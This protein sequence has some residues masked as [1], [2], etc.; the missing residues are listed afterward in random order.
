V[1]L[2]SQRIHRDL[3]AASVT[4][5]A[6]WSRHQ[7]LESELSK[8][9][10]IA[11]HHEIISWHLAAGHYKLALTVSTPQP[12]RLKLAI[13]GA[14]DLPVLDEMLLALRSGVSQQTVFFTLALP[15]RGVRLLAAAEGGPL[16]VQQIS[17]CRT[18][19]INVPRTLNQ[20]LRP[21]LHERFHQ[22]E[23]NTQP[24]TWLYLRD[25][26]TYP[27]EGAGFWTQGRTKTRIWLRSQLRLNWL[28]L[29]F[30]SPTHNEC[31]VNV[32][33]VS[34]KFAL[35]P[36]A[37]EEWLLSPDPM[38][39]LED[40]SAIYDIAITSSA[41]FVPAEHASYSA[42]DRRRLGIFV[43]VE[44]NPSPLFRACRAGQQFEWRESLSAWDSA[45][46]SSADLMVAGIAQLFLGN[47]TEANRLFEL[48]AD[49]QDSLPVLDRLIAISREQSL[50]S[51]RR[52]G[53]V[54]DFPEKADGR[55]CAEFA[56]Q[57][58]RI[59]DVRSGALVTPPS[60]GAPLF[61]ADSSISL[62]AL[63]LQPGSSLGIPSLE[64]TYQWRCE[65]ACSRDLTCFVHIVK[66]GWAAARGGIAGRLVSKLRPASTF[67]IQDD[68][69]PISPELPTRA[70]IPGDVMVEHRTLNFTAQ[71][72]GWR[73]TVFV[74]LTETATG[75]R[76]TITTPT[77]QRV[78]RI[79][80]GTFKLD[81]Q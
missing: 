25:P 11:P 68:H 40:G 12:V 8:F 19:L 7:L 26:N 45:P 75:K 32:N 21:P 23:L 71:S 73:Y 72:I 33:G 15:T 18:Q 43:Q 6:R 39:Q 53:D 56:A 61:I 77:G 30:S 70:W 67:A 63:S 1:T 3:S 42:G 20:A 37:V 54:D 66:Q 51:V 55:K 65:A 13:T 78:S 64:M 81:T 2:L 17:L 16:E 34:G 46:K 58:E 31:S 62:E 24:A 47:K 69:A 59:L 60:T 49:Q 41:H 4:E 50:E 79:C 29:R 9:L 36:H 74:G 52:D 28:L 76:L 5:P 14:G 38:W 10:E 80:A 48:S 57:I 27:P 22:L 44:A 35:Q